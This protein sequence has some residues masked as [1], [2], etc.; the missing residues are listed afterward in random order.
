MR[1][2]DMKAVMEDGHYKVLAYEQLK[3]LKKNPYPIRCSPFVFACPVVISLSRNIVTNF[4]E[5][6]IRDRVS[7]S[8][9]SEK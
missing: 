8:G 1:K 2:R 4:R 7:P 6:C 3:R 9:M 5:M